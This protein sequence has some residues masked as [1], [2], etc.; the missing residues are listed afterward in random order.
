MPDHADR[1]SKTEAEVERQA[2]DEEP[3]PV[4]SREALEEDL[5]EAGKSEEGEYIP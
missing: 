2:A 1:E 3:D 4:T 5:M